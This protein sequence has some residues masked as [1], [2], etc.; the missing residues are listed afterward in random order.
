MKKG[1]THLRPLRMQEVAKQVSVHVSTVSR[2]IAN[3]YMQTPQGIY[4]MRY[5]FTG[6]TTAVT[7]GEST[8][9]Q[10]IRDR[11]G[12]L[13][14]SENHTNPLS[15]QD[16]A[17]QLVDQGMDVSRRTVTKYRKALGIASSRQRRIY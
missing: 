3:K 12:N 11:I 13:I 5:F 4:D 1:T 16:L 9:W 2:A 8:S 14:Q 7:G 17:K 15:D 10:S 6:G